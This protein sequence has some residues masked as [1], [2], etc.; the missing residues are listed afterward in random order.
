[1]EYDKEG[2]LYPRVDENSCLDCGLCLKVCP[3]HNECKYSEP[4]LDTYAGYSTDRELLKECASG[5]FATELSRLFIQKGGVVFGVRYDES[6]TRAVY[7]IATSEDELLRFASSKYIQAEKGDIFLRVRDVLK[8]GTLVLFVGLPC[9]ISALKLFLKHDYENLYT[10]ELVCMGVTSYRIAEEYKRFTEN[11]NKSKLSFINARSKVN[12]WF[13]PHLEEHFIN[14]KKQCRTLFG[15]FFGHAFLVYNR[16]SCYSCQYRGTTGVADFRIGDFWGVQ[17]SDTF[18]NEDG[19][20]CIF[21]RSQKGKLLLNE[22]KERGFYLCQTDYS[23]ATDNNMS[24]YKNKSETHR[25]IRTKFRNEFINNG[26]LVACWKTAS[27][28]FLIKSIIP[29]RYAI[30]LK[31]LYHVVIDKK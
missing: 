11:K 5:G 26:F 12:G 22:L 21:V 3:V 27:L 25:I 20:S 2:F 29:S 30:L 18:W 7:S 4:Y 10:C 19:V 16:P 1:M 14:G 13:V 9:D 17:K 23:Y 28:G 31:R 6:Y 15:S 8:K 24:S